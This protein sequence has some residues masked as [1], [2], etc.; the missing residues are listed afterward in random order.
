MRAE[1]SDPSHQLSP[2]F[3]LKAADPENKGSFNQEA[4]VIAECT[5]HKIPLDGSIF[6]PEI[7]DFDF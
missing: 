1:Q 6:V 4:F 7:L 5:R 3:F 2:D